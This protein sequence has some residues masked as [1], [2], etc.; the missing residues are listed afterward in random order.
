MNRSCMH[1]VW[2]VRERDDD[3][4]VET[5]VVAAAIAQQ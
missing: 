3:D 4:D 2:G 1:A 5:A